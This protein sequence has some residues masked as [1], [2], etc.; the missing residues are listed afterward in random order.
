MSPARATPTTRLYTVSHTLLDQAQ[1]YVRACF[2]GF[3]L[4]VLDQE[5]LYEIDAHYYDNAR[6]YRDDRYNQRGL[7]PWEQQVVTRYFAPGARVY[8]VGAGGGREVIAL[9]QAGFGADG[10]ECNPQLVRSANRLLA[11]LGLAGSVTLAPRDDVPELAARYDAAIVGWGAYMLIRNR[12]R[13]VALL[14]KLAAHMHPGA[15]LLI[16]FFARGK[17]TRY[18]RTAAA[19]GSVI[20]RLRGKEPVELGDSL[21]PNYTHY[22]TREQAEAELREAGFTPALYASDDYGHAVGLLTAPE[23]HSL[24]APVQALAEAYD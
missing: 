18:F 24:P 7:W 11:D 8:V 22:F 17:E 12:A 21:S 23:P 19:V 20:R 13:R 1:A 14:T 2:T 9:R 6:M 5:Q 16:S 3:W 10:C 4:G 15:P